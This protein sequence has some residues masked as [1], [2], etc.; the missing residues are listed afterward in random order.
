MLLYLLQ[1]V[2]SK[3]DSEDGGRKWLTMAFKRDRSLSDT[4]VTA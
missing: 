1:K 2:K 3:Q 4:N